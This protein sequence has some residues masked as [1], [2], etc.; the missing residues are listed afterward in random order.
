MGEFNEYF[1]VVIGYVYGQ[2]FATLEAA[3]N[4]ARNISEANP[5]DAVTVY[6][7]YRNYEA[8]TEVT[9]VSEPVNIP[10]QITHTKGGSFVTNMSEQDYV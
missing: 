2:A 10:D 4:Y 6:K 1:L 5:E 7:A 3:D 9:V 8:I